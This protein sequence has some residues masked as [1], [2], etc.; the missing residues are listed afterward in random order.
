MYGIRR[1]EL[2][3]LEGDAGNRAFGIEEILSS[4]AEAYSAQRVAKK[5]AAAVVLNH[6]ALW[7]SLAKR[8][9]ILSRE[10]NYGCSSIGRALDS[11]SSGWGFKSLRPCL[12]GVWN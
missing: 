7:E 12:T 5:I 8:F 9:S 6:P 1:P 11:K 10:E 4:A 3:R 2:S